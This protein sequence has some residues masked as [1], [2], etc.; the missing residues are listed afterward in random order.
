MISQQELNRSVLNIR[1]R[2]HAVDSQYHLRKVKRVSLGQLKAIYDSGCADAAV[3]LLQ[4]RV[5]VTGDDPEF[6]IPASSPDIAWLDKGSSVGLTVIVPRNIGLDALLPRRPPTSP[7]FLLSLSLSERDRLLRVENAML[8]FDPTHATLWIGRC[9]NQDVW[10]SMVPNGII[11]GDIPPCP[12]GT[13]AR[14]STAMSKRVYQIVVYF[15]AHALAV[16]G[17]C[18]SQSDPYPPL[19]DWDHFRSI[20]PV[21]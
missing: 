1:L 19:V 7:G 9:R 18:G 13:G 2:D 12:I 8:G 14:G 15:L 20:N 10:L 16:A 5:E 17:Y 6:F 11:S 3:D 21:V 4:Y